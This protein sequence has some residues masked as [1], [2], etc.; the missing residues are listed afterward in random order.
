[1]LSLV[2]RHGSAPASVEEAVSG[3]LSVLVGLAYSDVCYYESPRNEDWRDATRY[4]LSRAQPD[5]AVI[6]YA[7]EVRR[8][9][10]YYVESASRHSGYP[11]IVSPRWDSC[12]R[13]GK[14]YVGGRDGEAPSIALL[15]HLSSTYRRVWLVLSHDQIARLERDEESRV[16]RIS[17]AS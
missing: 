11:V 17:L 2:G 13:V 12:F 4:V 6:L 8:P 10:D 7:D 16:V 14:S 15:R 3:A 1:M 5:G 9:F